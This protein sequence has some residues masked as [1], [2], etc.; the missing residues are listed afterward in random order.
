[1]SCTRSIV[2]LVSL[3]IVST[4]FAGSVR[5]QDV[6]TYYH[7]DITGS[8]VV[9]TGPSREVL[10][11][12][13]FTPYGE[14]V[15][16]QVSSGANRMWFTGHHH[17]DDSGLTYAG[18]RHYDP[19]IGRFM[20]V[21]PA[22]LNPANQ[23]TFNRYAYAN[24]SPFVYSDLDGREPGEAAFGLAVGLFMRADD[25]KKILNAERQVGS[26]RAA[27]AI[28]GG[29]AL[30]SAKIAH[31]NGATAAQ[32]GVAAAATYLAVVP[33][34]NVPLVGTEGASGELT[35]AQ[36]NTYLGNSTGSSDSGGAPRAPMHP[37]TQ[38][39]LDSV[40]KPSRSHGDCC[41]IDAINKALNKGDDVRGGTMGPVTKHKTGAVLPACSTCREVKKRLGVR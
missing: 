35:T 11:R 25:A 41:E 30:R 5:A 14:R 3:L 4:V 15:L 7:S 12:E 39:A 21:D 28:Q 9:A 34:F 32:I 1:M 36:G 26:G 37:T 18:A 40:K 33:A 6:I 10:W 16:Q 2:R 24:N 29:M 27:A 23:F 20:S 13:E 38:E 8:P 22:A 17:D 31:D 19:M